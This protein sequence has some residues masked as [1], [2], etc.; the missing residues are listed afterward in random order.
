MRKKMKMLQKEKDKLLNSY[1]K[2][3][4]IILGQITM[5]SSFWSF[6]NT[7]LKTKCQGKKEILDFMEEYDLNVLYTTARTKITNER[8]KFQRDKLN[9]VKELNI[10]ITKE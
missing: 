7:L 6:K 10:T 3:K 8:L 1:Q 5:K 9:V 4:H 2:N